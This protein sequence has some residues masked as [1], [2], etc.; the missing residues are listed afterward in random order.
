MPAGRL[1]KA[2]GSTPLGDPVPKR[3]VTVQLSLFTMCE[4]QSTKN[5]TYFKNRNTTA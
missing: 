3:L 2:D 4:A 1:V 5:P